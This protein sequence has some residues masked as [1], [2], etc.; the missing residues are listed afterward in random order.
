MREI[1]TSLQ[2]GDGRRWDVHG[3]VSTP[4]SPSAL[5]VQ[6]LREREDFH[7]KRN[8][9]PDKDQTRVVSSAC[10]RTSGIGALIQSLSSILLDTLLNDPWAP[11]PKVEKVDFDGVE[12]EED[13]TGRVDGALHP[14]IW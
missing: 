12:R 7:D 1:A 13:D 8:T 2:R 6:T 5:C 11:R 3:E 14:S 9:K 4:C 10:Q